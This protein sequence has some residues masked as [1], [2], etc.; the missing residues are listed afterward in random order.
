[1][2]LYGGSL[3]VLSR[4]EICGKSSSAIDKQMDMNK[5]GDPLLAC[6]KIEAS[7]APFYVTFLVKANFIQEV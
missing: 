5:E 6:L 4:N 3:S 2:F 7:N 1:M